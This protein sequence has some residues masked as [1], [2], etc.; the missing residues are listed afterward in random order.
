[1]QVRRYS[2]TVDRPAVAA[3]VPWAK[4]VVSVDVQMILQRQY[5]TLATS[6]SEGI[7]GFWAGELEQAS[8]SRQ[9]A[10]LRLRAPQIW[11]RGAS[12]NLK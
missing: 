5:P 11:D 12:I 10:P 1:M 4:C 9:R 8:S 7:L 6:S 3:T 2:P